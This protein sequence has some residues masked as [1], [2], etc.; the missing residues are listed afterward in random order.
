[1]PVQRVKLDRFDSLAIGALAVAIRWGNPA[2]W[3]ALQFL[4]AFAGAGCLVAAATGRTWTAIALGP[5]A[6]VVWWIG[7]RLQ[8]VVGA[9]PLDRA[10]RLTTPEN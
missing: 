1:M 7:R 4:G 10:A 5:A 6:W 2:A 3:L 8:A 9:Q